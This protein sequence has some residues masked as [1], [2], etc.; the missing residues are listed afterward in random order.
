MKKTPPIKRN[1]LKFEYPETD[2]LFYKDFNQ[3]EFE[4]EVLGVVE[5]DG[6]THWYLI[7]QYFI[8]KEEVNLLM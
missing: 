6:K 1:L 3:K 4:A 5:K 2:L 7:K 8:L